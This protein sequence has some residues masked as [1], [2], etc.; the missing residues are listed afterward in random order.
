MPSPNRSLPILCISLVLAVGLT[1]LFW[2]PLWQGG[3]LI[4]GDIYSYFFPQKT[5]FADQWTEGRIP[6]WNPLV[7]H[8]YPV[9]GE[10]Q[11]GVLYPTNLL[12]YRFLDV[13][14]AYNVSQLLHLVLAFAGM[15]LLAHRLGLR[16][17]GSILAATVYVFGWLPP[18]MCLE[19]APIGAAFLP[20][21]LLCLEGWLQSGRFRWLTP[22]PWL[23][24]THLLAGHY[25]LAFINLL[26][27]GIW[28][29]ARL[30]W[31]RED[32]QT[33]IGSHR[34][35]SMLVVGGMLA[36]GFAIA[37]PQVL[38]TWELKQLS[39][40]ADVGAAHNPGYGHI[41][42]LYLLQTVA[43]WMWYPPD[44]DF[45]LAMQQLSCGA[46]DE[47]TNKVEAHLYFGML[48]MVMALIAT[49]R[50]RHQPDGRRS[51]LVWIAIAVAATVYTTGWLL[52][53]T[54]HLPGFSY[55]MGPGRY[56]VIITLVAGLLAGREFDHWTERR[57]VH[58]T[59][60][61][62]RSVL[63]PV[64]ITLVVL[65]LTIADLFQ[66]SRWVFYAEPVST[67]PLAYR[68]QS[69]LREMALELG[70]NSR[71]FAPGPNLPTLTGF[72][73]SPPY[74]G[75][76]PAEYFDPALR[77][78]YPDVREVP[79]EEID[80]QVEWLRWAGVTHLLCQ[81]KL[82][83]Q[84]W[85]VELV[86]EGM[87]EMVSRSWARTREPLYLYRLLDAPG[88]TR[89]ADVQRQRAG[90]REPH[91][92]SV[93]SDS[94]DVITIE[95]HSLQPETLV[96]ADLW[97]PGWEVEIDGEI[98]EPQ[99]FEGM[100]RAVDVPAGQHVVT[101]HYRPSLVRWGFAVSAMATLGGIVSILAT[102]LRRREGV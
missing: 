71:L 34:L 35:R 53:L 38:A 74:L 30:F 26:V 85:P 91:P 54:Q 64:M 13:N 11:T 22:L 12:L 89:F 86:W 31:A 98:G 18:R 101:W 29:T 83:L 51:W 84:V 52:P 36:L 28:L 65:T 40:R 95:L 78:P 62:K 67:P 4:G 48:P 8:G 81:E 76:G 41:P 102:C 73:S 1:A 50:L 6:L 59:T 72:A 17:P 97:F 44:I 46:Y 55:F 70:P 56:G 75:L 32:C 33:Q 21:M 20:W 15:A 94:G 61:S 100:F 88:R 5:Y 10:S 2:W 90:E 42:P 43:P 80:A 16:V 49:W 23:L 39:Q 24:G 66:V 37:A 45:D 47:R 9:L 87:D 58:H 14:A 77:P 82:S 63:K 25:N 96:L 3:G 69:V 99:Q 60:P 93:V 79:A 68:E 92:P 7:G 57:D 27:C 19:W